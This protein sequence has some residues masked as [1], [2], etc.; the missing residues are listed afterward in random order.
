MCV[1]GS[2]LQVGSR[3]CR[4]LASPRKPKGD[5]MKNTNYHKWVKHRELAEKYYLAF[6]SDVKR[7]LDQYVF[8]EKKKAILSKLLTHT[9][10]K[11]ERE[12]SIKTKKE[13]TACRGLG[14]ILSCK[15]PKT[16][17]KR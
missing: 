9:K 16:K 5:E 7:E 8:G 6:I 12:N 13:E 4:T 15:P 11:K 17:R 10:R 1:F 2:G 3:N 14:K